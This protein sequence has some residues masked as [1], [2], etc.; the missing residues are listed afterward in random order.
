LHIHKNV[1]GILFEI[2]RIFSETGIN[3]S[4]QYLQTRDSVGYVVI[5]TDA[6]QSAQALKKLQQIEGTIRAR[7]LF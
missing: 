3:I 1:P 5:D 4:A 7:I 2:N 6:A